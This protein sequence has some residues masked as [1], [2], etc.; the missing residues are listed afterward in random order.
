M[1][2]GSY[3]RN[4]ENIF[5]IQDEIASAIAGQLKVQ[6]GEIKGNVSKATTANS[7]ALNN[8]LLG[9]NL[10]NKKGKED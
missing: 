6:F 3:E 5:S 7:S 8:Y 1:W 2:S 4:L 9:R 10:W